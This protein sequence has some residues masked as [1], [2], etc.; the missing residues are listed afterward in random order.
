MSLHAQLTP[1]AQARLDQQRRNSTISSIL[2]AALALGLAILIM[3]FIT[4]KLIEPQ[5]EVIVAYQ[6]SS[7]TDDEVQQEKVQ[8]QVQRKPTSS[9][10]AQTRVIVSNTVAP[11]SVPVTDQIV[12]DPSDDFGAGED[13][14]DGFGGGDGAG[15]G[16]G[17]GIPVVLTKRCSVEDRLNRLKESGGTPECE[18]AVVRTLD[19]LKETQNEDGSWV[20]GNYSVGMTGLALL[21]Y[22]GHCETPASP[23]YGATVLAGMTYLIDIANKNDGRIA[24]NFADKHWPY[25]H[26][27]ATYALAEAWTLSNGFNV[28]KQ[29]PGFQEAV[30][31]AGVFILENQHESGSWDYAYDTQGSRGGDNSIGG[32]HI[33]AMKACKLTGFDEFKGREMRKATKIALDFLDRSQKSNGG[34]SYVEKGNVRDYDQGA[35]LAAVG[36]LSFQI[37]GKARDGVVRKAIDCIQ[38]SMAIEWDA[39][40]YDLYGH[41]YAA[42]VMI[43]KGGKD[44]DKFNSRFLPKLLAAQKE[45][46]TW[47]RAG[48]NGKTSASVPRWNNADKFGVHYRTCLAALILESYYRFLP[49]SAG[50]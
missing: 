42:Q 24:A 48:E 7:E 44:W 29:I 1:E 13:F 33:Q 21:T 32:W 2:I 31:K 50:Q 49:A 27:I 12:T 20:G 39:P 4:M 14:G 41:Y 6:A 40:S 10:S 34:I 3:V 22:L 30:T 35:T 36:A 45:D 25:E 43:N 28:A 8:Q 38:E 16:G 47:G 23:N 17:A 37:N 9:S 11:V 15:A 46:G 5:A 19:W 18:E 26:S